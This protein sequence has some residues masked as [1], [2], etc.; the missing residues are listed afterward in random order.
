MITKKS[1][2]TRRISGLF[3]TKEVVMAI[4]EF[5]KKYYSI[6]EEDDGAIGS[7]TD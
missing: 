3:V 7:A 4:F 2:K 6:I 5:A 1:L